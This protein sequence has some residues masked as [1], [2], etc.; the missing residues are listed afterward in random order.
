M[1]LNIIKGL[2]FSCL[3]CVGF[4]VKS[5]TNLN[6][7]SIAFIAIQGDAPVAFAI[8]N[9]VPLNPGT[10][11]NFTDNKWTG[12]VLLTNEQTMRWTT[13]DTI[14]PPGTIVRFRHGGGGVTNIEGP[15]TATGAITTF[16]N[17]G[18]QILAYTGTDS[19]PSFIAGI[20]TNNWRPQCDTLSIFVFTT[21]LPAP[22]VNG[23]TAISFTNTIQQNVD[24]GYFSI[25]PF[26]GSGTEL[27]PIINNISYWYLDNSI[28]GAGYDAWPNWN[29]PGTSTPFPSTVQFQTNSI[30]ITEGGALASLTLL[31]NTSQFTPQTVVLNVLEF[32]GITASDY[33]TN[34]PMN[35]Q[36]L[37]IDIPPNSTSA[38]FTV[39]AY[40]DGIAEEDEVVTFQIAAV[41]GGL[42]IGPQASCAVTIIST[43]D[44]FPQVQFLSDTV[45]VVEGSG[46]NT[47]AMQIDPPSPGAH[48][49]IIQLQN[50]VGVQNDYLTTPANF[51]G[52]I[53]LEYQANSPSLSFNITPLTDN[54]IEPDEYVRA[55]ITT[56][57]GGMQIGVQSSIVIVLKD[58]DNPPGYVLPNLFINELNAFNTSF[59]DPF[60]QLDDWIELYNADD[61]T[62]NLTGHSITNDPADPTRYPFPPVSAQTTM[63]PASYKILWADQQTTQG[64]LHLNFTLNE[65]GGF[66][67]VY[68]PDG[69]TP[70]DAVFY[71]SQI[72]GASY[73]RF[74]DG[75][76]LWKYMFLSTPGSFNVDSFPTN[77]NP[78]KI[79]YFTFDLY[80]NPSGNY[81][82]IVKHG[83]KLISEL[84][85]EVRD[86]QGRFILTPISY[87]AEGKHWKIDTSTLNSGL[88]LIILKSGNSISSLRFIKE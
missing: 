79:D 39:Q 78:G 82:N 26:T 22:L 73:G 58:N 60:N 74:P 38:S 5:Q 53:L 37:V 23:L 51:N 1:K 3:I 17:Q 70:V 76:E 80:P 25:T 42:T 64:P 54:M 4:F 43:D 16:L 35:G 66:L 29:A 87:A 8:V 6:P 75:A 88:Y 30:T 55:T 71:P 28:P 21:C 13:P 31:L 49:V 77:N 14:L 48:F 44:N 81:V 18:D 83:Q 85:V 36:Q 46:A 45:Y 47:I 32:P 24:N 41:S 63:Q 62:I 40:A 19:S 9:L 15:G 11:I 65:S 52:S 72:N 84:N 67:G 69:E 59:P 27:L 20:S 34:P 57:T 10:V 61:V 86:V 2:L 7:G 12:T 56:V 50:G 68:A 33:G